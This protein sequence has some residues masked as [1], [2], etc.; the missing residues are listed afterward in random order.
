MTGSRWTEADAPEPV[1]SGSAS[2]A[3]AQARPRAGSERP[4][5]TVYEL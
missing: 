1:R 5:G 3:A 2:H 4:T